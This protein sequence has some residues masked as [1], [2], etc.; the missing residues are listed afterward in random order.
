MSE[1]RPYDS[2]FDLGGLPGGDWA[3][4][5]TAGPVGDYSDSV[6]LGGDALFGGG[7]F[8]G[9][10]LGGAGS[11]SGAAGL[12][13]SALQAEQA[14][15]A[16]RA[17]RPEAEAQ[18]ALAHEEEQA[19]HA[20]QE[21]E[22]YAA[23]RPHPPGGWGPSLRP[24]PDGPA[25]APRRPAQG[26]APDPAP[27]SP[28]GAPSG[29]VLWGPASRGQQWGPI[30][31]PGV[32]ALLRRLGCGPGAMLVG[33]ALAGG[34]LLS[35][36][37]SG[38]DSPATPSIPADVTVVGPPE[39][40]VD[41]PRDATIEVAPDLVTQAPPLPGPAEGS[42]SALPASPEMIRF[43]AHGSDATAR[44]SLD[45]GR[46]SSEQATVSLPFVREDAV[47]PGPGGRYALMVSR[48]YD[49][50]GGSD[51]ECR[52]YVDGVLV[53]QSRRANGIA[54]CAVSLRELEAR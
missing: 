18:A 37:S 25:P 43:E 42:G 35:I 24:R 9:D 3:I 36:F 15:A 39:G 21:A 29:S 1:I 16:A 52:I 47:D 17:A 7:A 14:S 46:S 13:P 23:P 30:Q 48:D 6:G 41:L 32:A 2:S 45:S 20:Q 11:A 31:Q 40:R 4:D 54:Y 5:A 10:A 33:L 38:D 49:A 53:A 26:S 51:L 50:G 44:V 19:A 8:G 28:P 34:L 27:G 12:P 22:R